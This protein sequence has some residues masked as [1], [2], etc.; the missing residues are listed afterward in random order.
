M[1]SAFGEIRLYGAVPGPTEHPEQV[2]ELAVTDF[3]SLSVG[4]RE[5]LKQWSAEFSGSRV[6]K[7]RPTG[8]RATWLARARRPESE[9]GLVCFVGRP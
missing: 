9:S 2:S 7:M 3:V 5:G 1:K 4:G 6:G 8:K